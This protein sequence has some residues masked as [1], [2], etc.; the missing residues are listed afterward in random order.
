MA[1]V[2]ITSITSTATGVAL[3]GKVTAAPAPQLQVLIDYRFIDR[4]PKQARRVQDNAGHVQLSDFR[5]TENEAVGHDVR[6]GDQVV[7]RDMQSVVS[8]INGVHTASVVS[9]QFFDLPAVKF[10]G[11][12]SGHIVEYHV[13]A[14]LERA[15]ASV[16]GSDWTAA[17]RLTR[18]G[19]YEFGPWVFT[20][21]QI[22]RGKTRTEEIT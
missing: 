7:A 10:V 5:N 6:F 18:R 2:E 17:I 14:Q 20:G 21:A 11:E 22:L 15:I 8:G 9:E 16:S 19:V 13:L 1:A 4:H 12:M 3:A